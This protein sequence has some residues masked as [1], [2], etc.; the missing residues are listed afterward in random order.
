M[1]V[2]PEYLGLNSSNCLREWPQI[3]RFIVSAYS[4][5]DRVLRAINEGH[6]HEYILNPGPRTD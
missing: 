4:D 3:G 6:A 1:S 5:A 2:C